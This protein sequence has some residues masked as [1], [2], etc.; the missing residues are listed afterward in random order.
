MYLYEN[1]MSDRESKSMDSL[2]V[3]VYL[4]FLV[5]EE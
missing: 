5:Y 1:I 2:V 4:S 3:C